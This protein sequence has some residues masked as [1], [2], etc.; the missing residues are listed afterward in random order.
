MRKLTHAIMIFSLAIA[1]LLSMP[2]SA[3]TLAFVESYSEKIV[4]DSNGNGI[5]TVELKA[6]PDNNGYVY[7][8][9]SNNKM[10]FTQLNN[11]NNVAENTAPEPYQIGELNFYR[12][13]AKEPANSVS[14]SAEFM[15]ENFFKTKAKAPE[16]GALETPIN[17]KFTNSFPNTIGVYSITIFIPQGDEILN[18]KTPSAYAKYQLDS[19]DGMRSISVSQ[20]KLAS[21]AAVT[22]NFNFGTGLSN[23][24]FGKI[25]LWILCLAIGLAVL[26]ARLPRKPKEQ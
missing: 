1:S 14:V 22:L 10:K 2:I 4:P 6:Q 19:Q 17:Y 11:Q 13:Q 12:I 21:M 23:S 26:I 18:V 25:A 15:L 20:K 16:T 9:A 7:L 3:T 8:V 24:A 5:L